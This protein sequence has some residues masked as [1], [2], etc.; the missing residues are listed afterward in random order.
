MKKTKQ[1]E[2]QKRLQTL[3]ETIEYWT[4][5]KPDKMITVIQLFYDFRIMF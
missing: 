3:K 4:R 1:K 2:W 5:N